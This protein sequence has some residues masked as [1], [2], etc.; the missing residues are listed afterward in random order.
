M[1][2]KK[3]KTTSFSI[4]DKCDELLGKLAAH[5][6]LSRTAWIEMMVREEAR[7]LDLK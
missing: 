6:G 1:N 7:K 4:T 5:Y 2:Q 3:R